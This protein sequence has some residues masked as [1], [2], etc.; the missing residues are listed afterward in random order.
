MVA[1]GDGEIAD[2]EQGQVQHRVAGMRLVQEEEAEAGD[3][4]EQRHQ[5]Q[6][7]APAVGR[8][9][10]QGEDRAAEA[11]RGEHD[12][13]PVDAPVGVGIAALRHRAQAEP[14]GR[15]DQRQVDP[16]DRPPGE[17]ADQGAA[18]GRAED[19]GDPGPG[20]PGADRL[21]A[22]LALEGGG[23][24]R[25]RARHQQRPGDAL[26]GAGADQELVAGS[27][28]AEGRGGAEGDQA[29][30]V[31]AAAAELVAEAA[32]D[33]HQR[34]HRQQVGLDHPLL[35]GEAGVETVGDRR[36][37]DVDHGGVE[38]D[39]GR[40]EDRRDQREALLAG[41]PPSLGSRVSDAAHLGVLTRSCA[42]HTPSLVLD[43]L[44]QTPGSRSCW[45]GVKKLRYA[46][47]VA[48]SAAMETLPS[49]V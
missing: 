47:P 33:Q 37:G 48:T 19:G 43:L 38:E 11:D 1:F 3:T 18:A 15:R 42:E 10:D 35:A 25:Q 31:D 45:A 32:A 20:G 39:D 49:S 28:R 2:A 17:E 4:G 9:L 34:D 22:R 21:A 24:D 30:H 8:L 12:S 46:R 5:H 14:D 40:A 6:R 29:D 23:D 7:V 41:H 27:D 16:E 36:Q 44:G 26:Q 13:Q